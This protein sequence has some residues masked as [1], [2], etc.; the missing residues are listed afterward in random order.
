MKTLRIITA[1][2]IISLLTIT[3]TELFGFAD[4][5]AE[6]DSV[7]QNNHQVDEQLFEMLENSALYGLSSDVTGVVESTLYNVIDYK[8]NYP[9]FESEEL[10]QKIS[11]V[12]VEGENHKLQYKAY[13]ALTFYQN[14]YDFGS[15]DELLS[16]L[17]A[18]NQDKIFF[19]IQEKVQSGHLT[20]NQ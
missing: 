17:E 19:F 11:K 1:T 15:Q 6:A 20:S 9:A 7:T 14:Q 16:L 4:A 5:D 18:N 8:V 2:V 13:L 10:V 12:A 3:T